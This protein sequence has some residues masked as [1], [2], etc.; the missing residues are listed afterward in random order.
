MSSTTSQIVRRI[1]TL[2]QP[3]QRRRCLSDSVG[4]FRGWSAKAKANYSVVPNTT[5]TTFASCFRKSP[6]PARRVLRLRAFATKGSTAESIASANLNRQE[7][8]EEDEDS[9]ET[10]NK[11]GKKSKPPSMTKAYFDL[12]KARLSL[13]VVTT[14]AAGFVAA[15][16]PISPQLDVLAA[17]TAGTFLCSASAGAM[18]QIIE[19]DR[20]KKMRRTQQRPLVSGVLTTPQATTAAVAWGITG[21][22]LLA[23]G[24]DPVTTLLGVGNIALYA[25]LYT[26]TKPISIYNTWIGAVVGA[27]P[28]VMGWTAATHGSFMDVEA[29]ILGSTLYLWQM[30]HFFALSFMHR[31]DYKRGGFQMVPCLEEDGERT[32]GIIVRY[33]WY[34]S[35]VPF[36]ATLTNVTSSMF[37][38]EGMALNGYA[39]YVAHKFHRDR[40]N[41]NA[42]TIFLTS[43]WY[44]PCLLMLFLL[45]SKTWDEEKDEQDAIS[46]NIANYIHS[47]R[48]TGGKMCPHEVA[49]LAKTEQGGENA[50]AAAC[51]ITIGTE[52]VT[53][54]AT[55]VSSSL[56]EKTS[57][58]KGDNV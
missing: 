49:V 32:A 56:Q 4:A 24:T 12:A 22:S 1:A 50:A 34:L 36:V 39:L 19:V 53:T 8:E 14:T 31:V 2:R 58:T 7:E 46:K 16:G 45:H 48:D 23:V 35:A 51:P 27:I 10:T 30:P 33:A 3:S 42:R 43:L 38:L 54:T 40:T 44:L 20:D 55:K 26:Y 11:G 13:L 5:P 9:N 41:A 28:P 57:S 47:I 37:A 25:G 15:G 18:N 52:K 29:L 17:V 6:A 21:T